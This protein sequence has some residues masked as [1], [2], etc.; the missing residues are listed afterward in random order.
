MKIK[1][2]IVILDAIVVLLNIAAGRGN[3]LGHWLLF[4]ESS[5]VFPAFV[6]GMDIFYLIFRGRRCGKM[7]SHSPRFNLPWLFCVILLAYNFINLFLKVGGLDR[8]SFEYG[9][10]AFLLYFVFQRQAANLDR[11]GM[12]FKRKVCYMSRGYIWLS[13]ISIIG[14][15]SSFL[16]YRMGIIGDVPISA[17]FLASNEETG[18]NYTR[19]FLSVR[20]FYLTFDDIR[21][22]FFQDNGIFCGLFHEPHIVAYNTFPCLIL[23]FGF[24]D[25]AKQKIIIVVSAL[26]M[27]LFAGSAT[28]VLVV[29]ACISIYLIVI[30]RE[31]LWLMISGF[32]I[33]LLV[34]LFYIAIDDTFF[35]FVV[36]RLDG[37]NG[38][39]EYSRNLLGY[40][41]SPES[42]TGYN[43]L[44]TEFMKYGVKP[45]RD[46][47]YIA[48]ILN[49][50]FLVFYFRNII[51]LVFK[52]EPVAVSVGFASL[53]CIIHS[54][55][56]GM[57][58]YSQM[59][60]VFLVLLQSYILTCYKRNNVVES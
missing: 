55:K 48:F 40:A 27:M 19:V 50:L 46:I 3:F 54:A 47:G 2:P 53:Y 41:F 31:N 29:I 4:T 57:T 59:L 26:L 22:P 58:M 6:I 28:N 36:D 34:I 18:N 23:L 12:D 42:L 35:Q 9:M 11:R 44:S 21:V 13:M 15:F 24:Y 25:K 16:L 56:I 39:N 8:P 37:S 45:G 60:P 20:N 33:V 7:S 14:V 10:V 17:D 52:K 5:F 32:A 38:S 51:I 49:I 30:G 43:F 1:R